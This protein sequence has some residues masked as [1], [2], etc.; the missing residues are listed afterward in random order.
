MSPIFD[1]GLQPERTELAWRRTA[2]SL[3]IGSLIA[4]R[5]LPVAFGNA[6]LAWAGVMGLCA[7]AFFWLSARRR[8]ETATGGLHRYGD[9]AALPGATPLLALASFVAAAGIAVI[10]LLATRGS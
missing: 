10:V 9:R 4:L 1:P 7:S 8:Y 5:L 2:L 3:G 6:I